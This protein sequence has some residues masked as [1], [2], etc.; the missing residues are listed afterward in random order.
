MVSLS[1]LLADEKIPL[2][3]EEIVDFSK[4]LHKTA[5]STYILLENLLEWSLLQHGVIKFNHETIEVKKFIENFDRSL[6]EMA[7]KKRVNFTISA[8]S[9]LVITA[10]TNMLQ[11]ILRNLVANAIKF[12]ESGGKVELSVQMTDPQT[13]LFTI[14]DSGI[15]MKPEI[16]PKLFRIDQNVSRNGTNGEPS[17]GLGLILCKEFV[18]K[19]GGEIWVKS[20]E[21]KG[22]TFSFTLPNQ[23]N[24]RKK[25]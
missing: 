17:T 24:H 21:G 5:S 2:T 23:N 15:G 7:V 22:S 14:T 20:V 3:R 8:P 13:V 10:D 19:H 18:D 12:T 1:E 16:L 25:F 9:N 4:S 11:T 6:S